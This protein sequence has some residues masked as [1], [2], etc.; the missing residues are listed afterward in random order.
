MLRVKGMSVNLPAAGTRE[1][2]RVWDAPVRIVHALLIGCVAGAWLTREAQQIDLHA[3]FGYCALA[4]VLFRIAWGFL[5]SRHARFASF[6]YSPAAAVAYVRDALRGEPHHYTG[7][8]PAGSWAVYGLLALVGLAALSG[9][10][11]IGALYG[12]GPVPPS[13]FAFADQALRWHEILAW[14]VLVLV[15]LHIVGALWGSYVH[16]EN[17]PAAM[18]TGR[19]AVHDA[20]AEDAPSRAA[21]GVALIAAVAAIEI[22]YVA[23]WSPRDHER[24]MREEAAAKATLKTQAWFKECGSCHLAYSPA[25]L[26]FASWQR[27]LDEQEKHFGEDLGLGAEAVRTLLEHAKATPAPSWAAWKLAASVPKGEAPLEVSV[28]PFWREAHS[29]L[30]DSD[31]KPPRSAGRHDCEACHQDAAS[32]IFH[33]RMI[34]MAKGRVGN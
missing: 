21:T 30:H 8:N 3:V 13:S 7:H 5:G 11:A 27:T 18:V 17:L 2:R 1:R 9:V 6:A 23:A 19:K 34:H 29:S 15:A 31:F 14:A 22:A 24:R 10:L 12:E 33:P 4:L 16:R 32:G 26:P 25:M 28:T 20:H